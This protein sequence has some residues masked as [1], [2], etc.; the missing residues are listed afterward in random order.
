LNIK[1]LNNFNAYESILGR[2]YR[3]VSKC[4]D[5]ACQRQE[6]IAAFK[7]IG[8]I[9]VIVAIIFFYHWWKRQTIPSNETYVNSLAS[10][11]ETQDL[12]QFESGFWSSRYYQYD[13]W[14][15]PHRLMLL[16]DP[17]TWKVKG[18]GSDDVGSYTIDGFYSMKTNRMGLTK[19]Y[20][21]GTGDPQ[22]N[23]GHNVTIQMTWNSTQHLFEGK[24][25]VQ[26][27]KYSGENKFE[28]KLEKSH[29]ALQ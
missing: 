27:N 12:N 15:G 25:F 26:T 21:R 23:L 7:L 16:F 4:K 19:T 6:A 8:V 3:G 2:P 1:I 29:K 28:L 20:Q 22:Q 5:A 17:E 18:S 9:I 13:I 11:I 24:W 10:E 14:H